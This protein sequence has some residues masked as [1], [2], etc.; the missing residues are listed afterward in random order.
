[1]A[2]VLDLSPIVH[3]THEQFYKLCLANRGVALER[4]PKGELIILTPVG[5]EGGIQEASLIVKVGIWNEQTGLG[6]VFSSSTIFN[7]PGGG[8]ASRAGLPL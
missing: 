1:M 5:G 3:F 8:D 4:S 7:L 2:T 6:F